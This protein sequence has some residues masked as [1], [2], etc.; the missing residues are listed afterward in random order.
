MDLSNLVNERAPARQPPT[1]PP[2]DRAADR[3][4]YY[5][6]QPSTYASAYTA[7]DS[8][9]AP[10]QHAVAEPAYSY[11]P[12]QP[13]PPSPPVDEAPG[14]SLP[15]ISTLL[16][17]IDGEDAGRR[18]QSRSNSL[19]TPPTRAAAASASASH[20]ARERRRASVQYGLSRSTH[21]SHSSHAREGRRA[22]VQYGPSRSTH[23]SHPSHPS[24]PL[25]PPMY[26]DYVPGYRHVSNPPSGTPTGYYTPRSS[27]SLDV[28]M[29]QPA[30]PN[31]EAQEVPVPAPHGL[32]L[33]YPAAPAAHPQ[34]IE[35]PPQSLPN[36]R[37]SHQHSHGEPC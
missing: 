24:H 4:L 37:L 18:R 13:P 7:A 28:G 2:A 21:P 26:H 12:A 27:L 11:A 19:L 17:S 23:P 3:V 30:M 5:R 1:D 8:Y 33:S 25:T 20:H 32:A 14:R 34:Y 15:S 10:T 6:S 29:Q 36:V 22:S 9:P 16:N 35:Y 31:R